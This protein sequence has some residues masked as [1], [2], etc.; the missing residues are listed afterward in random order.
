MFGYSSK[1][2][3]QPKI[4]RFISFDELIRKIVSPDNI[5]IYHEL[6]ELKKTSTKEVCRDFKRRSLPWITPNAMLRYRSLANEGEFEKNF[7]QSSGYVYFDIDD[8]DGDVDEYKVQLV[9]NLGEHASLISKSS[10]GGGIS[11]LFRVNVS[12]NSVADYNNVYDFISRTYLQGMKLDDDVK[13]FGAAWFLPFDSDVFFNFHNSIQVPDEI[14]QKGSNDVLLIT[15][16]TNIHRVTPNVPKKPK[17]Y[18]KLNIKD[19]FRICNFE[20]PVDVPDKVKI[21]PLKILSIRFPNVIRDG[22]KRKVFRKVIHDL[23]DL[24]P[25]FTLSHL[26]TFIDFINQ[27]FARPP[28]EGDLLRKVVES[29]F[30]YIQNQKT[31][32]LY[33]NN[34]KRTL[35][36][37]HYENRKN[38]S[39]NLRR[40][41]SNRLRGILDR[42]V[43]FK[44]IEN[45][46]N[47]LLEEHERYTN[48][49]IAELLQISEST[50]KRHIKKN[51]A[52]FEEEVEKF[53]RE[54]RKIVESKDT[55]LTDYL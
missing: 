43:N 14:F 55:E 49:E 42:Y 25:Q 52:S 10:T 1:P 26:Y 46:R 37:I 2:I 17:M 28:M 22:S 3:T 33:T 36:C 39:P 18:Q 30:E 48:K 5:E 4:E 11:I 50:V 20:T 51:K 19:V 53:E 13:R 16:H 23:I 12:I 27:N 35:R 38:I 41:L 47:Y 21:S 45:A 32:N 6:H 8:V 44:R 40:S 9:V 54:L 7:I 15:Q 31:Q 34:S 24:N 29:Q